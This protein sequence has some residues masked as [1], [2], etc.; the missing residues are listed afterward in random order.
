M[1]AIL[2]FPREN[3]I[4][5]IDKHEGKL[6]L[7]TEEVEYNVDFGSEPYYYQQD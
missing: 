1:N 3:E 4:Q 6:K 5:N 7:S 2:Y